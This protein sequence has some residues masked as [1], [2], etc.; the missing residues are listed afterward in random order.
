MTFDTQEHKDFA[1]QMIEKFFAIPPTRWDTEQAK[2]LKE[3]TDSVLKAEV[4]EDLAN[5]E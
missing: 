1:I 2:K 5:M 4:E 3:F